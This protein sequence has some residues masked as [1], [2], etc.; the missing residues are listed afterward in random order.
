M[1][2]LLLCLTLLALPSCCATLPAASKP[3]PC[4]VPV[5]PEKPAL[6]PQVCEGKVCLTADETIALTRY[7]VAMDNIRSA[8]NGCPATQVERVPQ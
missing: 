2:K 5:E 4:E 3:T 6:D 8:L 7:L 1:R